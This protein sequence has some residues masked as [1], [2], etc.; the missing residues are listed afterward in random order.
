MGDNNRH[1]RQ[2]HIQNRCLTVYYCNVNRSVAA[3]DML[4]SESSSRNADYICCTEPNWTLMKEDD[5]WDSDQRHDAA[6]LINPSA[7]R[8]GTGAG[9]VWTEC[10][11]FVLYC[12]YISPNV[13]LSA[14][15]RFIDGLGE[16]VRD[17]GG[18]TIIV[19]DF[20]AW[21]TVWG[22]RTTNHR[23][24]VILDWIASD[25][26]TLLNDGSPTFRR[27]NVE[28]CIELTICS[29]GIATLISERC[30]LPEQ[31]S[32]ATICRR[33]EQIPMYRF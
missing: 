13:D 27:G 32:L 15:N 14:F 3:H 7:T 26:L 25:N 5:N 29:P 21:S 31:Q 9:Y 4:E 22:S 24:N 16:S 10:G 6:I 28:S 30:V 8:H 20:N 33:S 12:C 17:Q 1:H 18:E 19:G 11:T 2:S 23:G